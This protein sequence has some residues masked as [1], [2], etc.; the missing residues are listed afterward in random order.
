MSADGS[1]YHRIAEDTA[2]IETAPAW[3]PDGNQ[4]VFTAAAAMPSTR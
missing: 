2:F 4:I 1:G 3:S